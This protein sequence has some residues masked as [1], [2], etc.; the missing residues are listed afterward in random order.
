VVGKRDGTVLSDRAAQKIR[1]RDRVHITPCPR[2]YP[3]ASLGQFALFTAGSLM[4]P[5][6]VVSYGTG[7]DS[8][9]LLMRWTHEPSTRPV[10][11]APE[12]GDNFRL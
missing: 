2:P 8:T 7:T 10:E 9:A 4:T 6:V 1:T 3:K 11:L 5:P 12:G